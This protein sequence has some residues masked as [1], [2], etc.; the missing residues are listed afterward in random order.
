MQAADSSDLCYRINPRN[1]SSALVL[2][3]LRAGIEL[4][5]RL[6]YPEA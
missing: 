5:K 3:V 1:A 2:E 6:G 4:S